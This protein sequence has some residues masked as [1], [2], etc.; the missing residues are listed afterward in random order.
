M[1]RPMSRSRS[2]SASTPLILLF[3][4]IAM[5]LLA[6]AFISFS[7]EN[8]GDVNGNI[9][10]PGATTHQ[11]RREHLVVS[12]TEDAN[13]ESASNVEVKCLV[14]GGTTIQWIVDDGTYVKKGDEIIV[15]DS[16]GIE[17]QKLQ[18]EG[19][20]ER[21]RAVKIQAAEDEG[22]AEISIA[23]Y[24]E[25]L[26]VIEQQTADAQITIGKENLK[27][28]ENLL[29]HTKK[30]ARKG[31]A[32]PSQVEADQFAVTR[33]ELELASANTSKK[34]LESFTKRK[35]EKQLTALYEAAK[36]RTRSEETT[37]KL[38]QNKYDKLTKQMANCKILAPQ[39][40]MVVYA[41][42]KSRS[43]NIEIEVGSPVRQT[44]TIVRLP[45]LAEMQ[46]K[47][48]V[49]ESKIEMLKLGMST[50]VTI[51]DRVFQGS[52]KH[53]SNQPE[54]K[55]WYTAQVKEY[56]TLVSFHGETEG[57]KPGMTAQVEITV[58]E[59]PDQLVIPVAA[60]VEQGREYYC[61]V[62]TATGVERR[63]LKLGMTD[64]KVIAV[65][66][67]VLEGDT[68][69][70]NPRAVVPDARDEPKKEDD[71]SKESDSKKK[72]DG[73]GKKSGDDKTKGGS[74]KPS[75]GDPSQQSGKSGGPKSG[76]QKSAGQ[77]PAG[78]GFKLPT[79]EEKDANKDGKITRDE[80]TGRA[81]ESF[82]T[83]DADGDGE[84]SKAEYTKAMAAIR[85]RIQQRAGGGGSE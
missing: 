72:W 67:G 42:E 12:V 47:V 13:L 75:G 56:A 84:I 49:N 26:Y 34:V 58:H 25:G 44:Q 53:I 63:V 82:D 15:L 31:F 52:V 61:W 41:N 60:V 70:L 17:E 40:G 55:S 35:M 43:G 32:S 80:L 7:A 78:G 76:G 5:G 11:I 21:A 68:V 20:L 85:T 1:E 14:A 83:T 77:K 73:K 18:Q 30:M 79:F 45:N 54:S 2:G 74:G 37:L 64:D 36:A 28:A 24:I 59:Y 4:I 22:A 65:D 62:K 33:A 71:D 27:S 81:A 50:K 38:E 57:L 19:I 16:A 8:G 3:S 46:A 6:W 23:E 69:I 51:Q 48:L 29:A 39:D 66:D 9:L 10:R